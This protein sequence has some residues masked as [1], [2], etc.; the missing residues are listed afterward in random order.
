MCQIALSKNIKR[1]K[2]KFTHKIFFYH[3]IFLVTKAFW[4]QQNVSY[5]KILVTKILSHKKI[6]SQKKFSHKKVL[7]TKKF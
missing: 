5:K 3:K 7:V 1:V 6:E 4:S 2:K